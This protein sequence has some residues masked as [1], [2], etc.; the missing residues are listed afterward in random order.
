MMLS[1]ASCQ[2]VGTWVEVPNNI[3]LE[4][5]LL[6]LPRGTWSEPIMSGDP[7]EQE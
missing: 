3:M 4:S 2:G 5:L 7:R 6:I 1:G